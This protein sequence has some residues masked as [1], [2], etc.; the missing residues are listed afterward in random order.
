MK[1]A[2]SSGV[3]SWKSTLT[4]SSQNKDT[5]GKTSQNELTENLGKAMKG[6]K[7]PKGN[8]VRNKLN[9]AMKG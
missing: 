6:F 5:V 4:K 9:Q 3:N 7:N 2:F 1:N 8:S